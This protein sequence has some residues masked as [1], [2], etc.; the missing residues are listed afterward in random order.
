MSDSGFYDIFLDVSGINLESKKNIL[1][2]AFAVNTEWW[3][4]I[5]DCSVSFYRIYVD[6]S[7]EDVLLKLDDSSHFVTILRTGKHRGCD[8]Y[9]EIG[10][11]TMKTPSHFLFIHVTE[12]DYWKIANKHKLERINV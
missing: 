7:F 9:G 6:M 10:F 8:N 4:D 11:S 5:L 2:D 3:V 1:H 12:D